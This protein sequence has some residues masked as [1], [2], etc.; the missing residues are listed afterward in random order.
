[1]AT[2]RKRVNAILEDLKNHPDRCFTDP[3]IMQYTR[4]K[5]ACKNLKEMK[6]ASTKDEA[7][8]VDIQAQ[9]QQLDITGMATSQLKAPSDNGQLANLNSPL[10]P[11]APKDNTML[12]IAIGGGVLLLLGAVVMV[13]KRSG[14]GSVAVSAPIAK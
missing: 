11:N 5:K 1:M 4:V 8:K 10:D 6:E 14:G 7:Q 13:M 12:Y 9:K 2:R 3:S